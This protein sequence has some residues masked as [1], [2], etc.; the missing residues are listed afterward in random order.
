MG[1]DSKPGIEI[2]LEKH[3]IWIS[4][5]NQK[6]ISSDKFKSTGCFL[7]SGEKKAQKILQHEL[8]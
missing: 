5:L 8:E 7:D 6:T 1:I 4:A 3:G 2:H